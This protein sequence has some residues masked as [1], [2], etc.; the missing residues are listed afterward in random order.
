MIHQRIRP[1]SPMRVLPQ[2]GASRQENHP[3]LQHRP[4][5]PKWGLALLNFASLL[6][7]TV[8]RVDAAVARPPSFPMQTTGLRLQ[9]PPHL[10]GTAANFVSQMAVTGSFRQ[11]RQHI[12][13]MDS[14]SGAPPVHLRRRRRRQ[15]Y[16]RGESSFGLGNWPAIVAI[17]LWCFLLYF[18]G[19][20]QWTPASSRAP[21]SPSSITLNAERDA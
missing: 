11:F 9:A 15:L 6:A 18:F 7:L 13:A 21:S 19:I 16:D 20:F 4:R 12:R 1:S 8:G 2:G 17:G 14:S 5:Q 10:R 3:A